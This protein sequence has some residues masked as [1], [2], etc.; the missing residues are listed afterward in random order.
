MPV[1]KLCLT[2]F[3]RKSKQISIYFGIFIMISILLAGSGNP[4]EQIGFSLSKTRVAIFAEEST[5]LVDGLKDALGD[6]AVFME[7]ED[8]DEAIQDALYFREI[9]YVIRIPKGFSEA[10]MAG[11]QPRIT[12]TTLGDVSS[13]I[14]ANIRVEQYF[15]IARLYINLMP[16]ITQSALKT[17][18][19]DDLSEESIVNLATGEAETTPQGNMKFY[20]NYLAYTFMFVV[21]MGVS[22]I[23]L[24]FNDTK[25]K[26]R[27]SCAPISAR[28][29]VIQF[30]MAMTVFSF[31]S[32]VILVSL[33]LYFGR[34]EIRN[35]NTIYFILN[36]FVFMLSISSLSFLIGN[37]VKGREA[38]SGA[39]NIITLG[40]CFLSGVF[41]P[42]EIMSEKVLNIASFFP[43][44]WYVKGNSLISSMTNLDIFKISPL[45]NAMLIQIGFAIAFFVI[46]MVIG[47]RNR[48]ASE[49]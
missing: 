46:A 47:K 15:N 24:V 27:N 22:T 45:S 11:E 41:V 18:V 35:E 31:F 9:S 10:F 34:Y 26:R 13:S 21:I 16:E 14:Y 19:L 1:F 25:I 36:S 17:F 29:T 23:M 30:F 5:P 4:N 43:T 3:K 12:K 44:Y 28:S 2:I 49:E 38:I 33:S 39:A 7:I 48:L 20:F 42:Q 6:V 40:A 37:L 32:W 8:S